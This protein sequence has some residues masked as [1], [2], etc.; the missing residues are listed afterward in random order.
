MSK[1]I[2]APY[3]T[4]S[5]PITTEALTASAIHIPSVL[6]DTVKSDIYHVEARPSEAG[7]SVVVRS[8]DGFEV[9]GPEFNSRSAVHEYG[10]AAELVHDG[11]AYFSNYSDGRI[12]HIVIDSD[13]K[14]TPI[15]P[16]DK[17]FRFA[18]FRVCPQQASLLATVLEDHT[19]DNPKEVSNSIALIDVEAGSVATLISGAD[20]YGSPR[21]SPDGTQLAWLEWN[22]PDMPWEG[23]ELYI[24]PFDSASRQIGERALVA[25]RPRSVSPAYPF[26][27]RLE[28]RDVLYFVS[29]E[30]EPRFYNP[31]V[32]ID[33][34]AKPLLTNPLEEDFGGPA[35]QLGVEVGLPLDGE[36]QRLL[37]AVIKHGRHIWRIIHP[38]TGRSQ[39]ISSPY[40]DILSLRLV[41]DDEVVF[42]GRKVDEALSA[43]HAKINRDGTL[44][45]KTLRLS[46]LNQFSPDMFSKPQSMTLELGKNRS[47][48]YI[49]YY[50]PTNPDYLGSDKIDELPP[51]IFS[52]HGGPTSR[53]TQGLNLQ[54]QYFT[55]RGW[56]WVDVNYGGSSGYG[57]KYIDRLTGNWGVVDVQDA[58]EA[59]LQLS[60]P[61]YSFID[62]ARMCIRGPSAGGYTT[63]ATLCD[64]VGSQ[65]FAAG[66]SLFGIADLTL[67]AE[68]GHKFESHYTFKLLGGTPQQV[69]EIYRNRSPL[70]NAHRIRSP[71]L[72]LQGAADQV[73]TPRQ[74]ELISHAIEQTKGHVEVKLY[75]GEGHGWRRAESIKDALEREKL[76]YESVLRIST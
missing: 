64:Q 58:I 8:R 40:V 4:W 63:L 42:T 51:C 33:G 60:S 30:G 11:I 37:F 13:T 25:G 56:A 16:K 55:S 49:N 76:F 54:T 19:L 27:G 67:D 20:F 1:P 23:A 43:V 5:S 7:R 17:P 35:W 18:D 38:I 72:I 68:E 75:E 15:T 31:W 50:P 65:T 26:W 32:Y 66:T 34:A 71:L 44:S 48:L 36:G 52:I 57:R 6:V 24:A 45:Y 69:P 22:H 59:A 39:E 41:S 28:G 73:V 10:G 3:G 53:A 2:C 46:T 29:D 70:F 74:A 47:P 21:F 9:N 61:P 62:P 14:P 12:Y